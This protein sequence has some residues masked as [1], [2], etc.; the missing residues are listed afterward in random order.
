MDQHPR[1][2]QLRGGGSLSEGAPHSGCLSEGKTSRHGR[3]GQ[4]HV[5]NH[6]AP[7]EFALFQQRV[8]LLAFTSRLGLI[9]NRDNL[10]AGRITPASSWASH[11]VLHSTQQIS[12]ALPSANSGR[13]S[14]T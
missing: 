7:Y 14:S 2:E 3:S 10:G 5:L 6:P 8:L 1:A 9:S 4:L 13:P 12:H 11:R